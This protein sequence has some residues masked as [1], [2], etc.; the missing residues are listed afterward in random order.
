MGGVGE[1]G[2]VH[3][4]TFI[5]QLCFTASL[6]RSVSCKI[7]HMWGRDER[8]KEKERYYNQQKP[9]VD[10]TGHD[11]KLILTALAKQV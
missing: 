2:G 9:E 1:G 10:V 6:L 7:D 5:S 8:N 3:A 4:H 11:T